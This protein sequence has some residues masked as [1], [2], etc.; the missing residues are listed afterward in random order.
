MVEGRGR[1][2][3]R[4]R[5]RA[6]GFLRPDGVGAGSIDATE[7]AR[8]VG[9]SVAAAFAAAASLA[10]AAAAAAPCPVVAIVALL[11]RISGC[12]ACTGSPSATFVDEAPSSLTNAV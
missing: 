1:S 3:P 8:A 9:F 12:A 11:W 6:V 10:A 5:L 2:E 4:R 7:F